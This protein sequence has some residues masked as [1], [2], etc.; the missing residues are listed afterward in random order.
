[1][2]LHALLS[3][4]ALTASPSFDD[5]SLLYSLEVVPRL[6]SD[7]LTLPTVPCAMSFP[8]DPPN[9]TRECLAGASRTVS[10][11]DPTSCAL[12]R[13]GDTF[14]K[15][16][17]QAAVEH[18]V[19]T[20]DVKDGAGEPL[21]RLMLSDVYVACEWKVCDAS[22]YFSRFSIVSKMSHSVFVTFH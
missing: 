20:V 4:S 3:L 22:Q 2:T 1:M 19:F 14:V 7:T 10:G 6:L 21:R 17:G 12:V 18:N 9:V 13:G 15:G 8:S 11:I 16:D 5:A